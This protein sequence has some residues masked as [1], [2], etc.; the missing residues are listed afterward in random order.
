MK[1][2][3]VMSCIWAGLVFCQAGSATCDEGSATGLTPGEA[4]SRLKEGN[5]R[6][7]HD[8]CLHPHEDAKRRAQ[9]AVEGQHPF[10]AVL[11]CS[12]SRVPVEIVFDQGIGDIFSIRVAGNVCGVDE[13]GTI[14]YVVEH[15]H[16]PLLVVLGHTECGAVTAATVGA[17]VHG[18]ITAVVEKILPAVH[19]AHVAHPE[20]HGK[21]L[22]P[23]AIEAN[24]WR[25]VEEILT[26]SSI[27]RHQIASGKLK[28]V[29]AIYD[30]KSGQVKWLGEHPKQSEWLKNG[31]GPRIGPHAGLT[32]APGR[33]FTAWPL[34]PSPYA[35][36]RAF[37]RIEIARVP[38]SGKNR[39]P[40][41]AQ[42]ASLFPPFR[43]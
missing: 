26:K 13:L 14:E 37:S 9:T 5:S 25:A 18:S 43:G 30:V 29:G 33:D 12:D 22:V 11:A 4:I 17:D 28:V 39:G 32:P 20:L 10:A 41:C 23:C 19:Q 3:V 8:H 2:T 15:L 36:F 40:L 27:A 38:E 1:R 31:Q 42:L 7:C 34:M 21:D 16:A 24:V 35:R 6:F